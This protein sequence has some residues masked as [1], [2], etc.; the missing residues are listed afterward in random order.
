MSKFDETMTQ[1]SLSRNW[2]SHTDSDLD[3][4][5]H[6]EIMQFAAKLE[7]DNDNINDEAGKEGADYMIVHDD[8]SVGT[9]GGVPHMLPFDESDE[10]DTETRDELVPLEEDED[11]LKLTSSLNN[12]D[13]ERL[14]KTHT[15]RLLMQK[16]KK[17][18]EDD[19]RN[20][21][22]TLTHSQNLTK[23]PTAKYMPVH[24][25]RVYQ[26]WVDAQ[27]NLRKVCC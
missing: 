16:E 6:D 8:D 23:I 1:T 27:N 9:N 7:G 3:K 2:G 15:L 20:G 17:K 25:T 5:R 24:K 21:I 11:I 26:E 22:R 13:E 19:F 4:V 14:K 18:R 12:I 10:D